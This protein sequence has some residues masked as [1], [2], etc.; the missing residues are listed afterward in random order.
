MR[1]H[2]LHPGKSK[3][4]KGSIFAV[5][6]LDITPNS[7]IP[8]EN[9][10]PHG[11]LVVQHYIERS[12]EGICALE[13]RWRKHFLDTMRPKFLPPLWSVEHQVRTWKFD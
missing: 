10:S 2:A 9:Y 7:R 5:G 13:R 6:N 3:E 11:K 12:G 8:N 1:P 4:R